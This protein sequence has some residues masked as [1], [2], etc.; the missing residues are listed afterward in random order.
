MSI[1]SADQP[2]ADPIR[3]TEAA[4][5]LKFHVASLHRAIAS[6]KLRGWRVLGRVYV[7]RAEIEKLWQPIPTRAER[8]AEN[9]GPE[10]RRERAER[11]RLVDEGLRAYGIRK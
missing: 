5:M 4:K 1:Y 2:P 10:T 6:G 8:Q 11:E 7:S 9:P 3:V